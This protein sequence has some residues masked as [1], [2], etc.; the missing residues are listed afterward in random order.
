LVSEGCV[1]SCFL[2]QLIGSVKARELCHIS[3]RASGEES[4]RLGLTNWVREPEALLERAVE[5]AKSLAPRPNIAFSHMK[6]KLNRGM[7]GLVDECL[8]L[9]D[10]NHVRC[11]QTKDH[12]EAAKALVEKREPVCKGR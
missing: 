12:K 4:L 10:A 11:G 2:A 6:E 1:S 8:D 5:I 9:E 3:E 7:S